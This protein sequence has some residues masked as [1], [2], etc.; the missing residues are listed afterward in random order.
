VSWFT[1]R[2]QLQGW[3]YGTDER[4][5]ARIETHE[6]YSR[7][8]QPWTEWLMG[9]LKPQGWERLL[10]AGCGSG[11][12][13]AAAAARLPRGRAV[14]VDLSIWMARSARD[15]AAE[16]G[17]RNI[18]TLVGDATRLPFA[19]G[20]F[21]LAMANHMLYHVP[22]IE[23]AVAELRRVLVP[24]GWLLAATNSLEYLEAMWDLHVQAA[25][26]VGMPD[27]SKGLSPETYFSLENGGA[28]LARHFRRVDLF[29]R[30]DALVF[31][32][33][34]PLVRYWAS[35]PMF[36]GT[37]GPGDPRV[38]PERWRALRDAFARLAAERIRENGQLVMAKVAGAFLCRA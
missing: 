10:D 16:R 36:R 8:R 23:G 19:D 35:G 22:S 24:G 34:E 15:A 5:R 28:Y 37:E 4:L 3:Q 1:D 26:A 29:R 20:C 6:R 13:L 12:V 9:V 38:A 11:A 33:P 2:S 18:Q 25:R 17:L 30:A 14:G 27:P 21:D 31:E 7:N 32:R